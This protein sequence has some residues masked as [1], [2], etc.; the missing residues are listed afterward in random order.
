[1]LTSTRVSVRRWNGTP[2]RGKLFSR[3]QEAASKRWQAPLSPTENPASK[4]TASSP[5]AAGLNSTAPRHRLAGARHPLC[6]VGEGLG[7][8]QLKRLPFPP[9]Q[10][11]EG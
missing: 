8:I 7:R 4:T 11:G 10:A 9:P 1:M 5:G 6:G 2:P 3:L